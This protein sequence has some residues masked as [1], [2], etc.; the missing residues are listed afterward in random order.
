LT[1]SNVASIVSNALS[2]GHLPT[3]ANGVYYVLTAPGVQET[4]GFLTQY[5]GW[6]T[7][8]TLNGLY[9]KYAFVGDAAGP[10]IGKCAVQTTSSPNGDPPADAMVS[11]MSHELDE[12]LSDPQLNAWFDSSGNESA[13]K[14]AWTFGTTYAAV[15]GGIANMKLGT[16]DFLIQQNWVNANGGY[17]AMS[18]PAPSVSITAPTGGNVSGNVNVTANATAAGGMAS[19][20]FQLDGANLGSVFVGGGPIFRRLGRPRQAPTVPM[21]SPP[22]RPTISDKVRLR[23]LSRS[24][25][26][27][28]RTS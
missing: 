2:S 23:A 4:S 21:R 6:H 27:M 17:C 13:D 26:R 18:V 12:S 3:D 7:Y 9:I 1:D 5:C 8:G 14:C 28:G 22:L 25:W 24:M 20:Q 10:A 16:R 19:L 11:V 15:G